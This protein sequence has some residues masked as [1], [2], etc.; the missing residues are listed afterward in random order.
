MESFARTSR[1]AGLVL[2][3]IVV[4]TE[5]R[6]ADD[7]LSA[8]KAAAL[9]S[10][11]NFA[12]LKTLKCRFTLTKARASSVAEALKGTYTNARKCEYL[13]VMDGARQKLESLTPIDMTPP[14][15][16]KEGTN[17][18][19]GEKGRYASRDFVPIGGLRNGDTV[20]RYAGDWK[21]AQIFEDPDRSDDEGPTPLSELQWRPTD[22][23]R[24]W[25]EAVGTG[26]ATAG[27]DG[28][29]RHDG[30]SLVH[31][32]YEIGSSSKSLLFDPNQGHLPA[33]IRVIEKG[34]NA[35]ASNE[36][37][38]HLLAA[39]EV[40]KGRWFP[41]H[42]VTIV[43][44]KGNNPGVLVADFEVT[45]L[46]IDKVTEEDLSLRIAAGT[47]IFRRDMPVGKKEYITL[48]Q[49]E[50]VSPSQI[51]QIERMLKEAPNN[52]LMDTALPRPGSR[53]Y[54][55]WYFLLG[56]VLALVAAVLVYRRRRSPS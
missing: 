27:S 10:E 18:A 7:H 21:Q 22:G 47:T 1:V 51:P 30:R 11:S 15:T 42:V 41:M 16:L 32:Q 54:T 3:L 36:L 48:R 37:Q 29:V 14:K 31:L 49:D 56:A 19:T 52:R 5:T 9:A 8:G 24:A 46:A 35:R 39:K 2:A 55:R 34:A 33:T 26:E 44:S 17:P 50:L 6:G 23:L 4:P 25:R 53:W 12:S 13:L 28:I 38:S 20:L 45:E 40:G 43:V